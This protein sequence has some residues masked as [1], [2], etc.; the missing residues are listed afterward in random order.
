MSGIF[1]VPKPWRKK[2]KETY[3]QITGAVRYS[4]K[5]KYSEKMKTRLSY[6]STIL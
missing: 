4:V 3:G 5:K 1:E 2:E 6:L